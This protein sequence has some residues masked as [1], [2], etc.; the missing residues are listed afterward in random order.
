MGCLLSSSSQFYLVFLGL[1]FT[2]NTARAAGE[3]NNP[4]WIGTPRRINKK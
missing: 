3:V 4:Y 2:C 1:L